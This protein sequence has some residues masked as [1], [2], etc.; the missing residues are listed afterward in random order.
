M[1][2]E[3][4]A[5]DWFAED[6]NVDED[7]DADR[8]D[9]KYKWNFEKK[10]YVI[11]IFGRMANGE[12]ISVNVMDFKPYCY[13]KSPRRLRDGDLSL[14]RK[15]IR[16]DVKTFQDGKGHSL[17]KVEAGD[18]KDYYGFRTET[19]DF[20]K[21]RFNSEMGMKRMVGKFN[22]I[23]TTLGY[24][25]KKHKFKVYESNLQ[26]VLRFM[27]LQNLQPG[28]WM[29]IEK[30]DYDE[31][32]SILQ[33]RCNVNV[34]VSRYT[35]VH[36]VDINTLAPVKI[37][38]WDIECTSSHGD[39][40]IAKK[41]YLKVARE[42]V[43]YHKRLLRNYEMNIREHIFDA[44]I[45]AFTRDD[46]PKT[47]IGETAKIPLSKIY[48]RSDD[49]PKN[50]R[51]FEKLVEKHINTIHFIL[52]GGIQY[53]ELIRSIKSA[54]FKANRAS[55]MARMN[56]VDDGEID[57]RQEVEGHEI[58]GEG[59]EGGEKGGDEGG[60]GGGSEGGNSNVGGPQCKHAEIVEQ[61]VELMGNHKQEVEKFSKKTDYMYEG[62]F[63]Q[64]EGDPIIQI[65]LVTETNGQGESSFKKEIIVL[66]S[67]EKISGAK[68][69]S[70]KTEGQLLVT[71]MD[72]I[73]KSD[74]D[75]VTGFN[76]LGFDFPYVYERA[77][78]LDVEEDMM[79]MT[80]FRDI[81]SNYELKQLSSS[82]LGD[83][84]LK[85]I[86]MEGRVI[87]DIMK[88]AQRDYNLNSYSLDSISQTFMNGKILKIEEAEDGDGEGNGDGDGN[89]DDKEELWLKMD[90]ILG[91]Q[92]KNFIKLG[93]GGKYKVLEIDE[94]TNEIYIQG[95]H[96]LCNELKKEEMTWGLAKDDIGPKEIF[97]C[98]RGS[99]KDRALVARYCIQDCVLCNHLLSKLKILPKNLGMANVCFV[100]LS[101][102]FLRGQGIKI[103]SLISK[104]CN[105]NGFRIPV[106]KK[107]SNPPLTDPKKKKLKTEIE[108]T[109]QK[110]GD[111][112]LD[113][114][115]SKELRQETYMYLAR[116]YFQ[117]KENLNSREYI[118]KFKKEDTK[119]PDIL[120]LEEELENSSGYEGAIVLVP[121]PGI[122]VD[123]P[124]SVLDYASLYPSSMISENI[125]HDTIVL[126]K[127]YDNL[128]GYEYLDITY[129]IFEEIK[130][131]V[132][133]KVGEKT[134]RF[135]QYPNG[136]K[137]MLPQI[138]KKVLMAR[139]NTRKQIEEVTFKLKGKSKGKDKDKEKD[140]N[141]IKGLICG[142]DDKSYTIK[143]WN[144]DTSDD[145]LK[146]NIK[147]IVLKADVIEKFQTYDEFEC[148]VLDGLQL[149]YKV[150]ANS[151][152]GQCGAKTSNISL[153]ELAASTT[154]TGRNMI[155][156]AKRFA[157]EKYGA[158]VVYGDTDEQKLSVTGGL[159]RV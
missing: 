152:Y 70:C 150:T 87:I 26:P 42:L 159:K 12:S 20:I 8:N 124:V 11:K 126:D 81:P 108:I 133:Q 136:E 28:G 45:D 138:L 41:S 121:K 53:P 56:A 135:V 67:C 79:F 105:K 76:I 142:E 14:I 98:H 21:L 122:Y 97:A 38:S 68:V 33:S 27:H 55:A 148:A 83:N 140:K 101:Y 131:G 117:L 95:P 89:G 99:A 60:D 10:K 146:Y 4:Q 58:K 49:M 96:K 39:F 78:E 73:N 51:A 107:Y 29:R 154:A 48:V 86:S 57:L 132:K 75:I 144:Y 82:A 52:N 77:L 80:K 100:P 36:N 84:F 34:E 120:Q 111:G 134:S 64:L 85:F 102:I 43:E 128:P 32:Q 31:T 141:T 145:Q 155:M 7:D 16:S 65:G 62:V 35:K 46:D 104:E 130:P 139:K 47:N 94:G 137:G 129:D 59:E 91:I 22:K 125:S 74:A 118:K 119:H 106:L 25:S 115:L 1:A 127:K 157:E 9:A 40:P 63:P 30:G 44:L 147:D 23:Q 15:F 2:I 19:E 54:E 24:L 93:N 109:L 151:I 37:L 90:S 71:F 5:I 69:F 112:N 114:N 17:Y 3:F 153:K 103:F 50:K 156:Q 92:E 66:G 110:L 61:L 88:V 72:R 18:Y 143:R 113:E 116:S 13:I 6:I 149:A 158:D 123:E